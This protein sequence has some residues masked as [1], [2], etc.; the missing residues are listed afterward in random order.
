[1]AADYLAS[2]EV[3]QPESIEKWPAIWQTAKAHTN[4]QARY[5]RSYRSLGEVFD[6]LG[7]WIPHPRTSL[8]FDLLF[9]DFN[10]LAVFLLR[11]SLVDVLVYSF[12]LI[13]TICIVQKL[14]RIT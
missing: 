6:E 14:S 8:R 9:L 11:K 4:P 2:R 10:T 5:F 7:A 12:F 3:A 1:M 13:L